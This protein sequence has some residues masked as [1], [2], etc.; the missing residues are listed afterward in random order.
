MVSDDNLDELAEHIRSEDAKGLLISGG[1]N[2]LAGRDQ[3]NEYGKGLGRFLLPYSPSEPE[4][5][6]KEYIGP[7]Y[8]NFLD[9]ISTS[10]KK[11]FDKLLNQFP[12]L[13]IFCH[14]YDRAFVFDGGK[15]L[16]PALSDSDKNIPEEYWDKIIALMI[17]RF[18]GR[19]E[20]LQSDYDGSVIYVDCRG[21]IGAK[22]QWRDELHGKEDGCREAAG[23]FRKAINEIFN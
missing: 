21:A 8:N 23:R 3:E 19:L 7:D 18:N 9:D 20:S 4:R 5:T 2:D 12:E 6:A 10:Y 17:D 22:D 1:G 14:G 13:K 11:L 16:Y 15:W